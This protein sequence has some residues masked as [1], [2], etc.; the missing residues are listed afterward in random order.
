[1]SATGTGRSWATGSGISAVIVRLPDAPLPPRVVGVAVGLLCFFLLIFREW[2]PGQ[3]MEM[4]QPPGSSE[5]SMEEHSCP[6]QGASALRGVAPQKGLH[7]RA[8]S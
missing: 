7:P 8:S 2:L 1:M 3:A 6:T 4:R 5:R